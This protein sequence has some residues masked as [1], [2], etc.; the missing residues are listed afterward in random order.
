MQK[1]LSPCSLD[2]GL[3]VTIRITVCSLD[4]SLDGERMQILDE[5]TA[6]APRQASKQGYL[7]LQFLF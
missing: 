4:G 2:T 5:E 3:E 6:A 1:P 7:A